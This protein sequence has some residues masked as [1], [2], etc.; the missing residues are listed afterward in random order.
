M[1]RDTASTLDPEERGLILRCQQGEREAFGP[2]VQRHMRGAAAFALAWTGSQEDALDLSQ[3]AFARAFRAISRFD[4]SRP[5]YPWFYKIL[6]NLCLNYLSR[7]ARL[8]EV[9]LLDDYQHASNEPGPDVATERREAR[10][11]VWDGIR[12]LGARD[13]EILI[14][15]EFQGLTYAEIAEVLDIP[16]GTVMSRLHTA[17]L[18][19]RKQLEPLMAGGTSR[20]ER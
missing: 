16:K 1:G 15:R 5:F 3:E 18:R 19:L 10:Q 9:P 14:L 17:R 20:R 7:A 11:M 13:R 8:R 6:R 2:I 4:P 12:K